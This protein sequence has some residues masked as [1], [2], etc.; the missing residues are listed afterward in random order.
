MIE[1]SEVNVRRKQGMEDLN[2]GKEKEIQ[3]IEIGEEMVG[4]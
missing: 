4:E 3:L 2:E 1:G